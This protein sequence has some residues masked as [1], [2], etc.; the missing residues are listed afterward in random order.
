GERRTGRER[1]TR[2]RSKTGMHR[3]RPR[4]QQERSMIIGVHALI[5]SP[6]AER[7]REFIADVLEWRSVD[8]G[9]GWLIFAMPP[10]ELAVHPT[11]GSVSQEIFLMCD[12]LDKTVA[13]LT[14]KNV[15][16]AHEITYESWGRV[17]AVALPGGGSIGLY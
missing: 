9:G 10:G 16:L 3:A 1:F 6:A 4:V 14:K 7:V 17:T 12:N 13:M 15:S 8:A 2:H 5:Y 11:S